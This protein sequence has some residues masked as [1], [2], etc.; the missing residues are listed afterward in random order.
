MKKLFI[1]QPMRGLTE[2][3]ILKERERIHKKASEIMGEPLELID[4]LF[5]NDTGFPENINLPVFYLGKSIS[6]LAEADIAYFGRGWREAR[7]CEIEYTIAMDYGITVM[8]E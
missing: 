2:E 5:N 1:S 4:L 7:G 3:E 6:L 8:E